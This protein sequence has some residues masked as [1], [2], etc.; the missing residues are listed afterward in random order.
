MRVEQRQLAAGRED[1][2]VDRV[3][4]AEVAGMALDDGFAHVGNARH[5][6]V[7]GEVGLDG[8]DGGVLDVPR[9]GEVR[10]AGPEIHQVGALSA[11]FR[12]LGGHGHGRGYFNAANAIGKDFLQE[13]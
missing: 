5:D 13:L 2:L 6:G 12:R 4:R 9:S 1:S 11:Q 8:G 10:L 3:F 7:A